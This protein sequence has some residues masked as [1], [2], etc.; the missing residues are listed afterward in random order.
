M[1]IV[2]LDNRDSFVYNLVDALQ[3]TQQD[4]N[5]TLS[6]VPGVLPGQ[7]GEPSGITE[8]YR[9][10]LPA[11]LIIA[12]AQELQ[13]IICLSPGP[14]TPQAAGCLFEVIRQAQ[15]SQI[16]LLGICLGFQALMACAGVEV[17]RVGPV[18]GTTSNMNLSA[19]GS[20][21]FG[22]PGNYRVPVARYHSLGSYQL[23]VG[24]EKWGEVDRIIMAAGSR[25]LL[26]CG[27]QFHPE[28]V[29]T[30]GGNQLLCSMLRFLD[31]AA[32]QNQV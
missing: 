9:N 18:H 26:S 25:S 30:Q 29:L 7:A 20:Q 12:R 24:W 23:P 32:K 17:K 2:M 16:P 31:S 14:G 19:E 4:Q 28:S 13:A 21:I 3:K 6:G 15:A 27:V 22:Y 1:N 5:P 10:D 8:V 11:E